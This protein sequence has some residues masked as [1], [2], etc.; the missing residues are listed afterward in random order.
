MLKKQ[1]RIQL[2]LYSEIQ[3]VYNLIKN[4]NPDEIH[5]A[6]VTEYIDRIKPELK[7]GYAERRPVSVW[8]YNHI[9]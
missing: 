5:K 2:V 1:A 9:L 8:T 4:E 6:T 7:E 3:R